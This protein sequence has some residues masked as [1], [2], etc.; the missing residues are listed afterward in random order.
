MSI[1]RIDAPAEA[2]SPAVARVLTNLQASVAAL[3]PHGR[4]WVGYSG[5]PDSTALLHA[6][7]QL[8]PEQLHAVHIHHGLRPE[9]DDWVRHCSAF[10]TRYGIPW[11]CERVQVSRGGAGLEGD[12]RRA[13]Y[14]AC[15]RLLSPGDVLGVAHHADDQAETILFRLLRGGGTQGVVG[16]RRLRAL[17]ANGQTWLWRPFLDLSRDSLRAY[18]QAQ[19]LPYVRD[20]SNCEGDNTRARLRQLLPALESIVPGAAAALRAHAEQLDAH[21]ELQTVDI[22]P[23]RNARLRDGALDVRGVLAWSG[24]RRHALLRSYFQCLGMT[25][26]GPRWLAHCDAELLG[27][28]EDAKARLQ[29]HGDSVLRFDQALWVLPALEAVPADWHRAWHEAEALT[30]PGAAGVLQRTPRCPPVVEVRFV[31]PGERVRFSPKERTQ[32]LKHLFQRHRIPPWQRQRTPV[33]SASG[34]LLQVGDWPVRKT[35]EGEP[36]AYVRWL[37]KGW[38]RRPGDPR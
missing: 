14:A 31:A 10:A 25:P 5:G 18:C 17:D 30:L 6:L 27:A 38:H 13:R 35:S 34:T 33:I 36:A 8:V 7:H 28:A 24:A 12:A 37:R 32:R 1:R 22:A 9:A 26:P 23:V 15:Q 3:P 2:A 20:P 4:I 29:L 19:D 21:Q 16:M 11:H